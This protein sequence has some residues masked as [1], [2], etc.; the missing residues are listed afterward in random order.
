MPPSMSSTHYHFTDIAESP[1]T[2]PQYY[3]N[4]LEPAARAKLET[5]PLGR[6]CSPLAPGATGAEPT[7][8]LIARLPETVR[9][10]LSTNIYFVGRKR[11]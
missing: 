1:R 5:L 9:R 6:I 4:A 11:G 10:A 7:L 2:V 3:L 8:G